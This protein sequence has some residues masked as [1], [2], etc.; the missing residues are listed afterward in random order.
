MYLMLEWCTLYC[1]VS[2][3]GK[4]MES[5]CVWGA[6][7]KKRFN[8]CSVMI[9]VVVILVLLVCCGF[10]GVM[11]AVLYLVDVV[12]PSLCCSCCEL[13]SWFG[14]VVVVCDGC[15]WL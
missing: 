8:H 14:C 5:F 2:T 15:V 3:A 9:K 12:V 1:N 11:D 4:L 7:K 13:C 6:K 10:V